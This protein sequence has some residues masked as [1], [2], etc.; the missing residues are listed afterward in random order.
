MHVDRMPAIEISAIGTEGRD[1][2]LKIVFQNYDHPEMRADR[3]GASENF[4]HVFG[5]CI[6]RD[7]DVLGSFSPNEIAHAT[8]REIGDVSGC[9]QSLDKRARSR[10]HGRFLPAGRGAI[11]AS[12]L[13]PRLVTVELSR[14]D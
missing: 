4:L 9:A 6:G 12:T 11:H 10:E 1:L 13:A 7:I 2:K 14:R 8:A 3:I 5:P